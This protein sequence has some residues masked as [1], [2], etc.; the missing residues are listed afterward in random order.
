MQPAIGTAPSPRRKS[1]VPLFVGVGVAGLIVV[2]GVV[3]VLVLVLRRKP[4]IPLA[5]TQLPTDVVSMQGH[6][7]AKL[8]PYNLG[9]RAADLP[10]A[11]TWSWLAVNLC[12]ARVDLFLELI[13]SMH[14]GSSKRLERALR[15]P[16]ALGKALRCGKELA[17][18][19]PEP[20]RVHIFTM[21]G[22]KHRLP[23]TLLPLDVETL[24]AGSPG[25]VRETDPDHLEGTRCL[26]GEDDENPARP[27]KTGRSADDPRRDCPR[28]TARVSKT[29]VFLSGTL[30]ALDAFGD[31]YSPDAKHKANK[32]LA[33]LFAARDGT[34]V[35]VG[36]GDDDGALA[37]L[38][39]GVGDAELRKRVQKTLRDVKA[40]AISTL[41]HPEDDG[42][43]TDTFDFVCSSASTAKDV[44]DAIERWMK[45]AGERARDEQDKEPKSEEREAEERKAWWSAKRGVVARG[46]RD[47]T[48]KVDG[49]TVRLVVAYDP[50]ERTQRAW[51]ALED[52]NA[53]RMKKAARI[54]D[55]LIDGK[56]PTDDELDEVAAGLPEAR[57]PPPKG[58]EK[59]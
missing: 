2:A 56:T 31:D 6:D 37:V 58:S 22:R 49:D 4:T 41:I 29:N 11:S 54:I 25:F 16:E 43:G 19:L 39:G 57:N 3:L 44:G 33:E 38:P 28:A 13:S 32:L 8:R 26:S 24:P 10:E 36:S 42:F 23:V 47:A 7:R 45:A 34:I 50:D 14:G 53:G 9:A 55:L 15:E 1:R 35:R 17:A 52:W 18:V 59:K 46:Y 48:V 12:G 30:E 40:W 5:W 20:Y 21:S 51:S 27:E